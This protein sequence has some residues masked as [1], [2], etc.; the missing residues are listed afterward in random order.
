M[1]MILDMVHL[2]AQ[3]LNSL[4][5]LERVFTALARPVPKRGRRPSE[6]LHRMDP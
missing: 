3:L 6:Y 2:T 5:R 4:P 1:G